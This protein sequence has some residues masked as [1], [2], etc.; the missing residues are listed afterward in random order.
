MMPTVTTV[1][2]SGSDLAD[3]TR[4]ALPERRMRLAITEP[5]YWQQKQHA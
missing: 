5:M 1:A 2:S 3:T 4:I